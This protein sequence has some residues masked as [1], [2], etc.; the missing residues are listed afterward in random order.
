MLPTL[1][2]V[3]EGLPLSSDCEI[4]AAVQRQELTH[5]HR[6]K[7]EV[8]LMMFAS[9]VPEKALQLSSVPVLKFDNSLKLQAAP[10]AH[11]CGKHD[12][13]VCRWLNNVAA[14]GAFRLP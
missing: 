9:E 5:I 4:V 10:I 6:R 11:I 12:C 8:H 13:H 14:G 2:E 7:A 1:A 3:V